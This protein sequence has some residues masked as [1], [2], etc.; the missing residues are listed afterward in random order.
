MTSL[1]IHGNIVSTPIEGALPRRAGVR[2]VANSFPDETM[3][4]G[5][6]RRRSQ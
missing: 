1:I 2:L 6:R 4:T 5:I 3:D